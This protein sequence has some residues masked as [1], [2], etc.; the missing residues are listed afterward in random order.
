MN[1]NPS[2]TSTD[3]DAWFDAQRFAIG[4]AL[5]LVAMYWKVLVPVG[6]GESLFYRD[7]GSL[8]YPFAYYHHESIWRG[9]LPEWNPLL[10]CGVPFL[11]QWGT[12]VLYPG[13]LIYVL[14]PLP[15]SL[16]FFCLAHLWLAGM[17]MY[18]LAHRLTNDRWAAT[19]AG[20]AFTFGGAT[21]SSLIYPN[22]TVALGWMPWV[23]LGVDRAC[24]EGK[25]WIV[26]GACF[27]ALQMLSGA[28]E[29]ILLTWIIALTVMLAGW[30]RDGGL[31]RGGRFVAVA[32]IVTGLTA[33]QLL[34]FIDLLA[35]SHRDSGF[36]GTFWSMPAWGWANLLVP[37]FRCFTTEQGMFV[38]AGQS[39]LTSYYPGVLIFVLA[40][41]A[42]AHR[43]DRWSISL[44]AIGALSLVL[45]LGE[46]GYLFV[47]LKKIFPFIGVA[48]YPIKLVF[49]AT[50]VIPLLAA[51][52]LAAL[53]KPAPTNPTRSRSL[54]IASALALVA[55]G[56]VVTMSGL[57]PL[58]KSEWPAAGFNGAFRALF[59]IGGVIA[60]T[61]LLKSVSNSAQRKWE[62]VLILIVWGD[63]A[64]Q[65]PRLSVTIPSWAFT[66]GI[67][68]EKLALKPQPQFGES[69]LA[70]TPAAEKFLITRTIEDPLKGF[71]GERMAQWYNLN[72]LDGLPKTSGAATLLA[73]EESEIEQILFTGPETERAPLADFLGIAQ[74]TAAGNVTD[75]RTRTGFMPLLTV[76][77]KPVFAAAGE[78]LAAWRDMKFDPRDI[79]YLPQNEK[80]T[81]S[82][83]NRSDARVL[84]QSVSAQ[85]ITA[86]VEAASPTLLVIAQTFMPSW[87]ATIDGHPTTV[88]RANH[89]FQAVEVPA[90]K[91]TVRLVYRERTLAAGMAS[92]AL[93]AMGCWWFLRRQRD[94]AP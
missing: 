92:T 47:W 8:A 50:F 5:L 3:R 82:A 42:L 84:S 54:W 15:W 7:Y 69:R 90:G 75:W 68:A 23:V 66:A 13:A 59:L 36:A 73:R 79:V 41:I 4:L 22:Y 11:A 43:R 76:G 30:K 49:A 34:P 27:G 56:G 9:E 57:R 38:Q 17:G 48:R 58:I 91:H 29:I 63:L 2:H 33:V 1:Q 85:R 83:T 32:V 74:L 24:A 26:F 10:H 51:F 72:L 93:T 87:R 12:M 46:H 80:A 44:V 20:V 28:P 67:A 6:G 25:R 21:L 71:L 37:L 52:T 55:I 88:L 81:I 39:F 35:H 53:A 65:V 61:A 78:A 86:E 70:L 45:A 14:L 62:A 40:T 18:F 94:H 64:T 77:Q 19:L 89:A 16:G 31:Q 60:L